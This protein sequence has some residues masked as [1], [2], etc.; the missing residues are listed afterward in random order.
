MQ[1]FI[2]AAHEQ[3]QCQA[4]TILNGVDDSVLRSQY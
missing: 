3:H 4:T 1:S 2:E